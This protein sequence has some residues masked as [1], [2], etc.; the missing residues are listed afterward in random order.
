MPKRSASPAHARKRDRAE[1]R[2]PR[3]LSDQARVALT[4]VVVFALAFVSVIGLKIYQERR[5]LV[6]EAERSQARVAAFLAERTMSRLARAQG[7]AAGAASA[8]EAADA[9][10]ADT[11]LAA[12][13]ADPLIRE[14]ALLDETGAVIAVSAPDADPD[15][16]EAARS[17]TADPIWSAPLGEAPPRLF[18]AAAL[19]L[20]GGSAR[21]V[22]EIDPALAL[23]AVAEQQIFALVD[24][25]GRVLAANAAPG[26]P[27]PG[28]LAAQAFDV[29]VAQ[30]D[31]IR[32]NAGGAIAD[33]QVG[34]DAHGLLG[35]APVAG[36]DLTVVLAGPLSVDDELWQSTLLFYLLL[37]VAPILVAIG[38]CA[39]LLMQMKNIQQAR[40]ML[41]DHERRFRLAVDGARCGVWDWD[42]TTDTV[43]MTDSLS[44]MFGRTGEMTL[45]GQEFLALVRESDQEKLAEAIRNAP[46]SNEVD[47][48]FRAYSRPVWLQ[49]RGRP[50]SSGRVMGVAIDITEQK[51]A[52]ARVTAAES[53]L[54]A[55][56]ESVSECFVLWDAR[57]RLVLSNKKYREFFNLDAKLV[58]PGAAYEMLELAAQQAIKAVHPS[59]EDG[60]RDLEL[61]DGRWIHF[62]ERRTTEGGLVSIGADITAMKEQEARLVGQEKELKEKVANLRESQRRIADL[63]QRYER[64]KV[65]AEEA[66]RAKSEFLAAMSHELRT[67]LNAIIGFSDIMSTEMFG[68][69][70]DDRYKEYTRD[71]LTSGQLLLALIN[72]ILDMSKI[73]AGKM[74]LSFETVQPLEIAEQSVRLVRGKADDAGLQLIVDLTEMPE[75]KADSRAVKQVLLNLMSNA[76]KF[77]PE[78]GKVTF[79]GRGYADRVRFRVIDSGIGI[80]PKDLKRIGRPFEQIESQQSK[81]HQGSGLGLALSRS[82]TELHGGTLSIESELG[83]GTAVTIELPLDAEAAVAARAAAKAET[84]DD[85]DAALLEP[86]DA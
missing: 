77:T 53:R 57:R 29:D 81:R 37:L 34:N 65:R 39:V 14:A 83:K 10:D 55:A 31:T 84:A 85:E 45:S 22:V 61:A 48:E 68:P 38:L 19:G 5:D 46:T 35:V 7:A 50:W 79:E 51:G 73:E 59:V 18:A 47:V 86:T 63:A 78:G 6:G 9:A 40:E 44:K 72:D 13:A 64:E 20:S 32:R 66:S 75:I 67:P 60:A 70:G 52:Q 49:A 1:A 42:L 56:L 33:A 58:T 17:Q 36:A 27:A 76:V 71:I 41:E 16:A 21:L 25:D 11:M 24:S 8:I 82:L 23:P 15:L 43:F 2:R 54:R 62:S 80:A 4:L 26:A 3:N 30:V 12:L 28:S 74:K 69:L